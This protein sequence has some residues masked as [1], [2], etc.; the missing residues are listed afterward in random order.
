MWFQAFETSEYKLQSTYMYQLIL[1][2]VY[3]DVDITLMQI[4]HKKE[5]ELR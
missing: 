1:I 2:K 3:I 4:F 5:Y